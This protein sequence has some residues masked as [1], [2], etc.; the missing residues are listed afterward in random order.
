MYN[1][2]VFTEAFFATKKTWKPLIDL[3]NSLWFF[4]YWKSMQILKRMRLVCSTDK[5]FPFKVSKK[6]KCNI[7]CIIM[8]FLSR[9]KR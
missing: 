6:V 3:L 1:A 5:E 9:K 2:R 7:L 8:F 4:Q